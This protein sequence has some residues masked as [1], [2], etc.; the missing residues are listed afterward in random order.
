MITPVGSDGQ[1]GQPIAVV[2]GKLEIDYKLTE[3][4]NLRLP[5]SSPQITVISSIIKVLCFCLF[6]A[7]HFPYLARYTV[8]FFIKNRFA[9]Q[10]EYCLC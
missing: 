10:L 4:L 2:K 5:T 1:G 7:G 8:N 9:N 6:E 3:C